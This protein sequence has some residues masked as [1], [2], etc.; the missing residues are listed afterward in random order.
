MVIAIV[1]EAVGENRHPLRPGASR[2]RL[3]V[4]GWLEGCGWIRRVVGYDTECG[5]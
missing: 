3:R 2:V 5:Y 4:L 1:V